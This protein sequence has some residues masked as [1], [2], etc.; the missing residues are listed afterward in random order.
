MQSELAQRLRFPNA[1]K[2]DA[3]PHVAFKVFRGG[4][5]E[6]RIILEVHLADPATLHLHVERVELHEQR[7]DPIAALLGQH[8]LEGGEAVE[9]PAHEELPQGPVCVPRS[10]D[11]PLDRRARVLA[12]I[13]EPG[14]RGVMT[15]DDA[16]LLAHGPQPVVV[17][18]VVRRHVRIVR[19]PGDQHSAAQSVVVDPFHFFDRDVHIVEEDLADA[20]ASFGKTRAPVREPPVVRAQP[21]PTPAVVLRVLGCAGDDRT[22]R[23]ERRHRVRERDLGDDAVLLQ[24]LVAALVVPVARSTVVLQVPKR[25]GVLAAPRVELCL[26]LSREVLAV[27]LVAPAGVTI[28]RDDRVPLV[29]RGAH[30]S[31]QFMRVATSAS[32]PVRKT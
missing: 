25:I 31:L 21:L 5:R 11:H 1:G 10:L 22:G 9:H 3:D 28:R 29:G 26:P 32:L 6:H 8:Q 23:E 15:D 4:Q 18:R 17:I 30:V 20:G 14:A 12:V 27:L 2:A 24:V 16:A 19:D 13:R 7:R